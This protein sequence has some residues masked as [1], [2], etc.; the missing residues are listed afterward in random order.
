MSKKNEFLLLLN[1]N[2]GRGKLNQPLPSYLQHQTAAIFFTVM[3]QD[4]FLLNVD[5]VLSKSEQI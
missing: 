3:Q 4:F 2:D 5:L 1:K